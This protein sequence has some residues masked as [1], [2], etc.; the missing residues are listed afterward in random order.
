MH[1]NIIFADWRRLKK[2]K[3]DTQWF[4]LS[5]NTKH[6]MQLNPTLIGLFVNFFFLSQSRLVFDRKKTK[7]K[8]KTHATDKK[9]QLKRNYLIYLFW[10]LKNGSNW[11]IE[12]GSCK[13]LTFLH[14]FSMGK[15]FENSFRF[16]NSFSIVRI[17][18]V[19]TR[20]KYAYHQLAQP[21]EC[22]LYICMSL[23]LSE[24]SLAYSFKTKKKNTHN[25][26]TI[27]NQTIFRSFGAFLHIVFH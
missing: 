8:H 7:K 16:I 1:L 25:A 27:C 15:V 26:D 24:N 6:F 3:R 10:R 17:P 22:N 19:Q 9:S 13:I 20:H 11:I 12:T 23:V 5:T 2:E 14:L 21:Q 4:I 18:Y